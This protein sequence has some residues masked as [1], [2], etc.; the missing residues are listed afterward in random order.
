METSDA[1]TCVIMAAAVTTH[2]SSRTSEP[3]RAKLKE[4]R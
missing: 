1:L 2:V 3:I 4:G